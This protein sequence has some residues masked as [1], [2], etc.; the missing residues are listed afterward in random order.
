MLW[1]RKMNLKNRK[2][3]D[4]WF[5]KNIKII[6]FTEKQVLQRKMKDKEKELAIINHARIFKRMILTYELLGF[7]GAR[8]IKE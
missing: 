3:K 8:L 5:A 4:E 6:D 2:N 1:E 7:N